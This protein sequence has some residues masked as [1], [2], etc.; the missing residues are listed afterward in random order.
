MSETQVAE[1]SGLN[2]WA[3]RI[4]YDGTGYLGW[5]KQN[6]G[7]S[8]QS[9][10]EAAAAKLVRNRPVPSITAGRTDAGVHAA[11]MVIHLDFPDD[12][13]IDARQIRDGMGYHL[14]PHRVVVLEAAA[15]EQ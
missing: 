15:P 11:G 2:R 1:S 12:A 14:K 4:E 9:L 10:I 3:L 8:I 6:D 7:I 5:Q 13:P